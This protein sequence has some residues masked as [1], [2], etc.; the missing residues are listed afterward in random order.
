MH[1]ISNQLGVTKGMLA[2]NADKCFA[3]DKGWW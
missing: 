3:D 1:P 2:E